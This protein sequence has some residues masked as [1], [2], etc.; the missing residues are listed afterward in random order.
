MQNM[1]NESIPLKFLS[2]QVYLEPS[3]KSGSGLY[4]S[5]YIQMY[6]NCMD[7]RIVTKCHSVF[8]SMIVS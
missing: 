6:H 8:L 3:G 5:V 2:L 1:L 7:E 4:R